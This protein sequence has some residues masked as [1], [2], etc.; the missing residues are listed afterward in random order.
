MTSPAWHIG[1][2]VHTT[3][4]SAVA[5]A[6]EVLSRAVVGLALEGIDEHIHIDQTDEGDEE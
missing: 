5:K 6:A 2:Y 3:D 1:A 4:Q